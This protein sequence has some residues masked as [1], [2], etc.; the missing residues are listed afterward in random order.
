LKASS[1]LNLYAALIHYPVKD[2]NGQTIASAVTNLDLHDIARAAKTYGLRSFYVV[3]PLTDQQELVQ[4][5]IAHWITGSGLKYNPTRSLALELIEVKASL[6]QVADD[7]RR[8]SGAMPQTVVTS[9]RYEAGNLTFG[10]LKNLILTGSPYL[11]L[12][13]TA[14]GLSE[15]LIQTADYRLD[16]VLGGTEYNHLSVRCAAAVIFDRLL[17]R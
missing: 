8:R 16:P 7:I 1:P 15:E 11:L 17:G 10:E 5:I 12:F 13:G 6:A 14:W 9:A 2:K 4:R 3:T